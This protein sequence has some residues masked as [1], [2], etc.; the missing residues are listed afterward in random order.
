MKLKELLK[1]VSS[2]QDV[3]ILY[4]HKENSQEV[5]FEGN[6]LE[7]PWIYAEWVL[8]NICGDGESVFSFINEKGEPIIGIYVMEE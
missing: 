4:Y 8:D 7:V 1:I 2:F 3:Q 6:V 5:L